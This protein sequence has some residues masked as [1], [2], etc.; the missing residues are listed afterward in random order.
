[1]REQRFT[2]VRKKLEIFIFDTCQATIILFLSDKK[3]FW[4]PTAYIYLLWI[5]FVFPF[6]EWINMVF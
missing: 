4:K 1:M 2:I 6:R 3:L 5:W